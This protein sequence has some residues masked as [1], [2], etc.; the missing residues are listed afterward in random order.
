M[1]IGLKELLVAA[2]VG[3]LSLL[4]VVAV[5]ARMWGLAVLCVGALQVLTIVI[6]LDAHRRQQAAL[7][8]LERATENVSLRVVTEG[9]ATQRSL[10]GHALEMTETLVAQVRWSQGR[11]ERRIT[12]GVQEVEALLQLFNRI[13]PRAAMPSSGNWAL[14]PTGILQLLEVVEKRRPKRIVQL[15][16]GTSTLWLAYALESLGEGRVIALE[17]DE[18]YFA[19]TKALLVAHGFAETVAEVRHAP[20]GDAGLPDHDTPWYTASAFEDL[21]AVDLLLVDGPPEATGKSARYP[22]MPAF[23]PKLAAGAFVILDDTDRKDEQDI[24]ERW[25]SEYP[26]LAEASVPGPRGRQTILVLGTPQ[27]P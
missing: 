1:K 23:L 11:N 21:D 4:A 18:H 24:I 7:L 13:Q 8:R 26:G 25:K 17:H 6:V 2:A 14:P 16:S 27:A 19:E 12:E 10:D 5:V 15:G 9:Q 20:L 3:I 22:A